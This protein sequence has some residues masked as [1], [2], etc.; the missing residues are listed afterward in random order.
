M[1]V[2]PP[3]CLSVRLSI[4]LWVRVGK[5]NCLLE[6][7][8]KHVL[9]WGELAWDRCSLVHS[10]GKREGRS[11]SEN[12]IQVLGVGLDKGDLCHPC[13]QQQTW[14]KWRC[15]KGSRRRLVLRT[16]VEPRLAKT[17]QGC[18]LVPKV[19]RSQQSYSCLFLPTPVHETCLPG[20]LCCSF[21]WCYRGNTSLP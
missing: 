1:R 9:T 3:T 7:A 2:T 4:T 17:K 20:A 14:K 5:L 13:H 10:W 18:S 11:V 21:M 12:H 8:G 15:R 6:A 16:N 19:P